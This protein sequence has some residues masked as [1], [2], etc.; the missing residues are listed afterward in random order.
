MPRRE[1]RAEHLIAIVAALLVIFAIG[2]GTSSLPEG[3]LVGTTCAWHGSRLVV[4]G[5]LVNP[6][7]SS[8][9]FRVSTTIRIAGRPHAISRSA[10]PD[11]AG[12]SAGRWSMTYANARKGLV[13]N[14]VGC[15]TH[16]RTYAPPSGED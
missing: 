15:T 4:S 16:I 1:F 3:K 7:M 2:A 11:L 12:F 13:G 14:T 8:A 10:Y 6:G 9:Q 5:G